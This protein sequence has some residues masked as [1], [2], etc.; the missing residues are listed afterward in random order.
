MKSLQK[1]Y[2]TSTGREVRGGGGIAPDVEIGLPPLSNFEEALVRKSTFFRFANYFAAQ[3][4]TIP[5]DFVPSDQTL[6]EFKAWLLDDGFVFKGRS[7]WLLDELEE[8]A[9]IAEYQLTDQIDELRASI[10][11]EKA[12]SFQRYEQELTEN[13]RQEILARYYGETAQI[14][15]S[16]AHDHQVLS[17]VSLLNDPEKVGQI[18]KGDR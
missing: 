18:L 6:N 7:E 9:E 5:E 16:L 15:A 1:V 17:A 4:S 13:L 2:Q 11:A 10:E 3:N 12:G 8:E 14:R